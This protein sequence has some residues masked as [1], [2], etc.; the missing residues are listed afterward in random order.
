MIGDRERENNGSSPRPPMHNV[1]KASWRREVQQ[2]IDARSCQQL[3]QSQEQ[4]SRAQPDLQMQRITEEEMK[5]RTST[6]RLGTTG[7]SEP[8][9][10]LIIAF[11]SA[12]S[13]SE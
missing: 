6:T 11:P 10:S 4:R 5:G 2:S 7:L 9:F 1:I 13:C 3:A 8:G 12:V